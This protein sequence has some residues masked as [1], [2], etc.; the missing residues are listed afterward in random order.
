MES[1]FPTSLGGFEWLLIYLFCL[2][3]LVPEEFKKTP[4]MGQ[5][6]NINNQGIKIAKSASL[7]IIRKSIENT[8]MNAVLRAKF[9]ISVLV[10]L[11][12]IGGLVLRP[13]NVFQGGKGLRF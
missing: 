5:T 4:I 9:N 6:L 7:H 10:I 8:L 3:F 2:T 1:K 11:L 12:I 13:Q